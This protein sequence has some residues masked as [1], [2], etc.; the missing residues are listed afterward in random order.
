MTNMKDNERLKQRLE[1][2]R[3]EIDGI[4]EEIVGLINKRLLIGRKN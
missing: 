3:A 2:F 4:D 1:G